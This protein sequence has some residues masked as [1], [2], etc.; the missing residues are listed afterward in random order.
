M[1]INKPPDTPRNILNSFYLKIGK[2]SLIPQAVAKKP[3][4]YFY[5]NNEVFTLR[6]SN[7]SSL[8][9]FYQCCGSH[10]RTATHPR[11]APRAAAPLPSPRTRPLLLRGQGS[12]AGPAGSARGRREVASQGSIPHRDS[13][14]LPNLREQTAT[15]YPATWSNTKIYP[16]Y[17]FSAQ[18]S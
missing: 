8:A 11:P 14:A 12:R 6:V 5:I 15:Y 9:A 7:S 4:S 10:G 13:L 18:I 16:L 1:Y 2:T 17:A 3:A